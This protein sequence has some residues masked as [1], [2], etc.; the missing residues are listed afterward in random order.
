[1]SKPTVSF[2]TYD[3]TFGVKPLQPNGCA[4]YRCYLPMKELANNGWETGI[5]IPGFNPDHGFGILIPDQKAIHGWEIVVLKLIMLERVVEQVRQARE[6]GQ[7]IVVDIDDHMEGLEETNLAYKTTDPSAN[8]NNNREHYVAIMNQADALITSTPFLYDWYKEKYPNKPIFLVR[9]GIDVDRWTL[10]NDHKGRL[11]TFGWVGATPW[12]SGDLE[13]LKPYFGQFLKT[14][15]LKF[16]HAGSINYAPKAYNQAGVD[17]K[18]STEEPMKTMLGV[19]ELY[20][21]KIDVGIVP[22][23]DVP[24]NHA[25][26]YL[27][28]MEYA[29]AGVPFIAT[30]LAE[31]KLLEE[32][33]VGRTANTPQEWIGHMEELLDPKVRKEER[34]KN[35]ENLKSKFSM[36]QRGIEWAEVLEKIRML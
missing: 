5:G 3:W 29:A 26:S 14:R 33:G 7:K 35:L 31:Y 30:G 10:H 28:G 18:I 20:S 22:L 4:W 21:R 24:F 32:G 16:H 23:R 11:P 1:M 12:R 17:P 6:L 15:H 34:E 36:T 2:L 27:K 19:P 9:N 8:P 13:I 25:K